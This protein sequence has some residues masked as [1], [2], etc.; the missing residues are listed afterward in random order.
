MLD[1]TSDPLTEKEPT[2]DTRYSRNLGQNQRHM[3][4]LRKY[5]AI[6]IHQCFTRS[7]LQRLLLATWEQMQSFTARYGE[8]ESR[9]EVSITSFPSE[10]RE[11][12]GK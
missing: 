1:L 11:S 12:S 3:T 7:S 9:L 8:R 4:G 10:P 6:L 5:S 2:P